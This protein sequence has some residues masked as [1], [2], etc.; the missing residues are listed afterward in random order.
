MEGSPELQK[1][2]EQVAKLPLQVRLAIVTG[3]CA[4]VA[5]GYYGAF[6]RSSAAELEKLRGKEL[7]LQRK[8]SEVRSVAAN[9]GAFE[10]EIRE[11]EGRL[12]AV[13]EQLPDNKDLEVLLTDISNLGK[14]SGVE[15]RSFKRKPEVEHEFYGE[16]PIDVELVGTYH[17]IARFFDQISKLPRIVNMGTLSMATESESIEETRLTVKGTATTFRFIGRAGA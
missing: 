5:L 9:I 8:L 11:L 6:Y 4:L 12:D 17:D 14:R 13:L 1:R 7:E 10:E 16:V 15:I 2:L 3:I